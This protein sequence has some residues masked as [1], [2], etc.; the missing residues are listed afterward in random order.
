MG[1]DSYIHYFFGENVVSFLDYFRDRK[2]I[3]FLDEFI[4]LEEK[5]NAHSQVQSV[6][7]KALLYLPLAQ[8]LM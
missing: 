2:T 4:R 8:Y 7:Y 1:L 5:A 3:I 6:F